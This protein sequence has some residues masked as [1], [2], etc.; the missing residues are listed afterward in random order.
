MASRGRS[1]SAPV[2]FFLKGMGGKREPKAVPQGEMQW[3]NCRRYGGSGMPQ[4][5]AAHRKSGEKV[6]KIR[7]LRR[8][9]QEEEKIVY[10]LTIRFL[11][12]LSYKV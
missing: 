3:T 10:S 9:P 6:G 4:R 7:G 8:V 2:R 5:A 1:D 11:A 12:F